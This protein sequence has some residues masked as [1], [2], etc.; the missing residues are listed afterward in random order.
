VARLAY[1]G[2]RPAA[3]DNPALMAA[4]APADVA[5]I[6]AG[7][8]GLAAAVHLVQGGRSVRLI[9]AAPQ[10]GG[11][12]RRVTL[13]WKHPLRGANPIELDNGQHLLLGAYT[14]VLALL[15]LLGA[16]DDAHLERR[17]MRL[18]SSSG[19]LMQRPDFGNAR[20]GSAG[21]G[22]AGALLT[23]LSP[24]LALVRAQGLSAASRWALVR[25]LGQLRLRAWRAPAGVTTV[26]DW[27]LQARQ[28]T[29][30]I[31][32]VWQPLVISALN[33]PAESACASTFLRVLRDS[34]GGPP[35]ASDLILPRRNL[36]DLFV[37]PAIAWLRQ[38]GAHL[39]LRSD[40]RRIERGASRRYRIVGGAR[41]ADNAVAIDCD[42][43]VLA[44][45]PY[46][47]ARL[48][49]GLGEA[50]LIAELNRFQYLPI[51]TAY[52][53]WPVHSPHT[54]PG[55]PGVQLPA[56][57][58]LRESAAQQRFAQWFFDRGLHAGWRVGALV[59]SDSRGARELGDSRLADALSRQVMDELGLPAPMQLSLIHEKRATIACTADRP[60][61]APDAAGRQLPGLVLAGD[62]TYCDYPATLEGAVRSG[63]RA[64]Q[65]ILAA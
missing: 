52:L 25:A 29:E 57:L 16:L 31:T 58:S 8:A 1:L 11:R 32:R 10:A 19:L 36:S 56:L 45:P 54:D 6:G 33:T 64:A 22:L 4:D 13:N 43:V 48:L 60:R 30:L 38:H 3:A 46:A 50:A 40:V 49:D 35:T 5:V 47:S 15:K 51:T 21:I 37:D 44:T 20:P 34:L 55:L 2:Q 23:P 14:E 61:L 53:G 62:Y 41:Q 27:Y 59:L 24:L 26:S 39:M 7:W 28:P 42:Q 18:A 63:R 65:A 9:D 17:P 12:A